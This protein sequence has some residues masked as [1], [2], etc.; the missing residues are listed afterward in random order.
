[1]IPILDMA[2]E[3]SCEVAIKRTKRK[4]RSRGKE[5]KST[6]MSPNETKRERRTPK[7][8]PESRSI[9]LEWG[10]VRLQ[11]SRSPKKVAKSTIRV[12]TK[13]DPKATRK[14]NGGTRITPNHTFFIS[15]FPIRP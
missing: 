15:I 13:G 14:I 1:M 7:A 10:R 9:H 11:Y 8:I 4:R 6:F 12:S 2:E 5:R 3:R